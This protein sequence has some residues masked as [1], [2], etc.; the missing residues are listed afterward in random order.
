MK[1]YKLIYEVAA[2]KYYDYKSDKLLCQEDYSTQAFWVVSWDDEN[3]EVVEWIER[4]YA[5][6]YKK[7]EAFLKELENLELIPTLNDEKN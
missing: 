4:F 2:P 5:V 1:N 6:D 3:C 7:A